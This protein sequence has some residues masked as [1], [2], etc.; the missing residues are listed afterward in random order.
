MSNIYK[1]AALIY[2]CIGL[3]CIYSDTQ[4]AVLCA[5]GAVLTLIADS[6]SK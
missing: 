4:F 3:L 1:L 5:L 2:A 6:T